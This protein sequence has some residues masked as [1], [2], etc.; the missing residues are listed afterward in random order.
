MEARLEDLSARIR[1]M[2][3]RPQPVRR[4]DI[5]K[6]DRRYRPL[7]VPIL[8]GWVGYF[9][10]GHSSRCFGYVQ[11][12]V[13]KKIRRHLMRARQRQGFGWKRWSRTW[14][15]EVLGLYDG[16]RIGLRKPKALPVQA[17]S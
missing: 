5:P 2:G 8:R 17:V 7:G 1:R 11:A 15:Y 14:L 4:S 6:G 13:E 9:R 3:Y 12:W 16:Y 10:V